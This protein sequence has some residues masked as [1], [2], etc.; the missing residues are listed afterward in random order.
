MDPSELLQDHIAD[1]HGFADRLCE[2]WELRLSVQVDAALSPSLE[3]SL[4]TALAPAVASLRAVLQSVVDGGDTG[5]VLDIGVFQAASESAALA[6]D[7]AAAQQERL[8]AFS[9]KVENMLD[10]W[11]TLKPKLEER[12]LEILSEEE[13]VHG[14]LQAADGIWDGVVATLAQAREKYQNS[15]IGGPLG[16]G[17]SSDTI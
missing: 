10:G 16:A 11:E 6:V 5:Q 14:E 3:A 17:V 9:K 12:Q 4:Y 8:A 13:D 2:E 7:I 1:L 15:R